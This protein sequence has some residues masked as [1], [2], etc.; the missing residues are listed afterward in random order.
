MTY[1]LHRLDSV[2]LN[3]SNSETGA[4]DIK[5]NLWLK[6]FIDKFTCY[7]QSFPISCRDSRWPHL[8]PLFNIDQR[9]PQI[10]YEGIKSLRSLAMKEL[11]SDRSTFIFG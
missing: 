1:F 10:G 4:R 8:R 9:A 5:T 7:M 6:F 3:L 2:T 11:F